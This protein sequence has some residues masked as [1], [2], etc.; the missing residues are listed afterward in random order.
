VRPSVWR[1][2]VALG[3]VSLFEVIWICRY[4]GVPC[5][6]L[7]R[8]GD[9][10]RLLILDDDPDRALRLGAEEV[11]VGTFEATV[12]HDALTQATGT[13]RQLPAAPTPPSS[14]RAL[15]EAALHQDQ[16][17][18][19]GRVQGLLEHLESHLGTIE[20]SWRRD[21]NGNQMPFQ[22]VR[23]RGQAPPGCVVLTTFGQSSFALDQGRMELMMIAPERL[24]SGRLPGFLLA[25][26]QEILRHRELP[27]YGDLFT[28][29]G[30]LR[31]ISTMD[32]LCVGRPLYHA[33]QFGEFDNG[34]QQVTIA[35]LMPVSA[36]EADYIR[37][38]GVREFEQ[39]MRDHDIDPTNFNR[40]SML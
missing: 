39:L 23:Y 5:R 19:S 18:D 12:P 15:P 17:S 9:Q 31:S 2:V 35:W 34:T 30:P 16:Q 3:E 36:A 28:N 8:M 21:P 20:G 26:G 38:R 10:V 1:R 24:A 14:G 13:T 11:D 40:A 33:A 22:L 6:L 32:T 27:L 25:I 4:Q 7:Q 37:A 29:F